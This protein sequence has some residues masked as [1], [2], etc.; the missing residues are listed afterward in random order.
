MNPI[1]AVRTS[2]QPN[3]FLKSSAV[4]TNNLQ[5]SKSDEAL[6]QRGIDLHA[7][8]VRLYSDL[9]HYA[10]HIETILSEQR[11]FTLYL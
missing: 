7:F 2:T 11:R 4:Q 6:Q 3:D 10:K 1:L 5:K 8:A 9:Q